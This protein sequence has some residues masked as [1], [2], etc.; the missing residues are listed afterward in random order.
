MP[1]KNGKEVA[2]FRVAA[3]LLLAAGVAALWYGVLYEPRQSKT[4]QEAALGS[5]LALQGERLAS[6]ERDV[7][8]QGQHVYELQGQVAGFALAQGAFQR[9]LRQLTEW[10]AGT[11]YLGCT[12]GLAMEIE[13]CSVVLRP[14]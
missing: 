12:V 5:G 10:Q 8:V 9:E 3:L 1:R 11:V 7:R 13:K 2:V 14:K 6:V 4:A